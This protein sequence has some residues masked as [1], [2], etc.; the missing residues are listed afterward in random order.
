MSCVVSLDIG[1]RIHWPSSARRPAP[2]DDLRDR[3]ANPRQQFPAAHSTAAINQPILRYGG[4]RRQQSIA[5]VRAQLRKPV[6][7]C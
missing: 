1:V 7:V 6:P 4:G 3:N 2:S 5:S